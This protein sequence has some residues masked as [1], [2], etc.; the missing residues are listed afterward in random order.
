M[1]APSNLLN[2]LATIFTF[3]LRTGYI[4][5]PWKTSKTLMFPKPQKPPNTVSSNC[6]IQ[7]TSTISKTLEE[8]LV[9]RLHIHLTRLPIHQ[10]GF[11]PSFSIND[12]LLRLNNMI[13]N[14]YNTSKPS[15]LVLF[16]L[17]NAFD[18]V[19]HQA[20]IYKR[21]AF[22]LPVTYFRFILN[23]LSKRLPYITI[24][25]T[26]SHPTFLH[27]GIPQESSLSPLLYLL[28]AADLPALPSN[29]HTFQYTDDTAFLA[30]SSSIQHI[31]RTLNGAITLLNSCCSK[32]GLTIN[33]HKT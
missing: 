20:I 15:C 16:D 19:W 7:L 24:N 33:S 23:F 17:E 13:K 5:L 4:P 11:R 1:E 8:I 26:L 25:K 27:C 3:I 22:R 18:R 29:I 9:Q 31:N 10:A 12:Q 32:W 6:L 28:F 14:Q 2:L 30:L 21:Q